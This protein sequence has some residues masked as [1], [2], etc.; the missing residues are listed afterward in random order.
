MKIGMPKIRLSRKVAMISIGMLVLLGGSGAAALYVGGDKLLG[1][2]QANVT[3]AECK[4]IQTMVLKT[5]AKRLWL[6]KYISIENADG[7]TRIR[8]ALRVAGLLAKSNAVDLIQINVLDAHGPEKRADM[9]GRAIGAEV[10]FALEPRYLPDME[11]P[12]VARYFDGVA[13]NEGRFY[14]RKITLEVA[15]IQKLMTEMKS[16]PDLMDCAEVERPADA[17]AGKDHG[18]PSNDHAKPVVSAAGEHGK[19][20]AEGEHA[21][22]GEEAKADANAH[23]SAPA[24]EQSFLDSM[25]GMVGLGGSE[26]KAPEGHEAKAEDNSHTVAGDAV[27]AHPAANEHAEKPQPFE[28][29]TPPADDAVAHE[30]AKAEEHGAAADEKATVHAEAETHQPAHDAPPPEE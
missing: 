21:A 8:T 1:E 7:P 12:F 27:E 6:R 17:E 16:S 29:N 26:E 24:K 10:I 3:G 22:P 9:R 19:P 28:E 14:G 4:T 5:P 23:E 13:N 2:P 25:L 30:P 15:G 11:A 20:A 18:K